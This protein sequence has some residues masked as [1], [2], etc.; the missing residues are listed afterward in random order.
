MNLVEAELDWIQIGGIRGCEY[1]PCS[2]LSFDD[3]DDT[4]ILVKF[5]VVHNYDGSWFTTLHFPQYGS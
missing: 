2:T 3:I 4:W 5:H 1:D